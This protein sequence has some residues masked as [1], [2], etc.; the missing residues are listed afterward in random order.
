MK[1]WR[2]EVQEY[3]DLLF[4][5]DVCMRWTSTSCFIFGWVE[6]QPIMYVRAEELTRIATIEAT[7]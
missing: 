5:W 4:P 7:C 6:S 3:V 2:M 1:R